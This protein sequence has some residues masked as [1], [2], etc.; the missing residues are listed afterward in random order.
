[1]MIN[2]IKKLKRVI[3][4]KD[5]FFKTTYNIDEAVKVRNSS[6]GWWIS[7]KHLNSN[8]IFSFGLGEDISFDLGMIEKYNVTVYG[9]DPTPKSIRYLDS[10][11]LPKNFKLKK[12][13]ISNKDGELIFNLPINEN[14]VSGSFTNIKSQNRITVQ[15]KKLSTILEELEFDIDDIDI[16]KMDIEGSEYEVIEDMLSNNIKPKQLLVEYHH[17]FDFISNKKTIDNIKLL[18]NNYELFHIEDYN[19]SFIRK[20]LVN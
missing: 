5:F 1:M 9:F 11:D 12:Y 3:L 19:Y 14:H 17:F 4:G 16:V 6:E 13:A 18:L 2:K 15:A 8:I 7:P 20:D 10:L